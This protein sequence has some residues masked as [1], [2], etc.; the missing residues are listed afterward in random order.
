MELCLRAN[1]LPRL[2]SARKTYENNRRYWGF[3]L[4]R[5]TPCSIDVSIGS[6]RV[7]VLMQQRGYESGR[8]T[9][10]DNVEVVQGD[11]SDLAS[12]RGFI[13]P[14]STVVN[15][16]YLWNAGEAENLAIT[17]N[18]LEACKS[19]Q[20]RRLIHS[21][22]AAVVGRACDDTVTESTVCRPVTE[23]GII[24][25]KI[26]QMIITSAG[27]HF[28][29][30]VLRP[31]SVFGPGGEPLKK[32]AETLVG[33]R[34]LRNYFKSCFFGNRRMNWV[35]IANVVAAIQFLIQRT[36]NM[37]GEVYIV[38]DDQDSDNNFAAVEQFLM[39][40]LNRP[41]YALPRIPFSLHVLSLLLRLLG[42][43]NTNPRTNYVQAKLQGLGFN[44]PVVFRDGLA[45]Y[46]A[47][48]RATYVG[49]NG[50]IPK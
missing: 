26:E 12:L 48:Y 47:W 13:E 19:A 30:V 17:G 9:W 27:G 20:V 45:E 24:K 5:E 4:H 10:P 23:Y 22:T 21:S 42:R 38:S 34:R 14:G 25:L 36:A 3:G 37:G 1:G 44:R 8:Y 29:A 43:N 28:D 15:L 7:K 49:G 6:G 40:T 39:R 41:N 32:L 33:G 31:T 11:M 35:H 50:G 18:L 2:K 16:V 46:A